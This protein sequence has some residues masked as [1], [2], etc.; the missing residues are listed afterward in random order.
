[1]PPGA[2]GRVTADAT[3]AMPILA[4]AA[5]PLRAPPGCLPTSVPGRCS[6]LPAV[7][8]LAA[9]PD[10]EHPGHEV[11]APRRDRAAM[12][13][14]APTA[15]HAKQR[16]LGTLDAARGQDARGPWRYSATSARPGQRG[17]DTRFMGAPYS[18]STASPA[19]SATPCVRRTGA[20]RARGGARPEPE[21]RRLR[22]AA[23]TPRSPTPAAIITVD[24]A[25]CCSARA[26][27]KLRPMARR[28]ARLSRPLWSCALAAAL[29]S[30][31]ARRI[32]RS[33]V[34]V[35]LGSSPSGFFARRGFFASIADPPVTVIAPHALRASRIAE[36]AAAANH[37]LRL[38]SACLAGA[39]SSLARCRCDRR[40][41]VRR[42]VRLALAASPDA[43]I[44]AAAAASPADL[45]RA[46]RR[47]PSSR[48]HD[49][50]PRRS[51]RR[52]RRPGRH[53]GGAGAAP[54]R[55]Q[56]LSTAAY[57]YRW[58]GEVPDYDVVVIGAASRRR[59][60][61]AT[62]PCATSR[63]RCREGRLRSGTSSK[64]SKR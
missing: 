41:A 63:S 44:A 29:A 3:I 8:R 61:R 54:A 39:G 7:R 59:H 52:A 58:R 53:R 37:D 15:S 9:A 6:T 22:A 24:A 46:R 1:M 27:A 42:A 45:S 13:A 30:L 55:R 60:L 2:A 12:L 18:R 31:A 48:C 56:A 5:P 34:F 25:R 33:S 17:A 16:F 23:R 32:Q 57:R 51:A 20:R 10:M 35:E 40:A 26:T 62:R 36:V 19:R 64:S 11:A 28:I 14:C 38:R 4:A 21:R 43:A 50:R 49:Q 47:S